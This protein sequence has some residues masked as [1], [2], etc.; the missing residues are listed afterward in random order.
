MGVGRFP[1]TAADPS[2]GINIISCSKVKLC[3]ELIYY[4]C[5]LL[6]VLLIAIIIINIITSCRIIIVLGISSFSNLRDRAADRSKNT[7]A[8]D[9][10]C[11][12]SV[13]M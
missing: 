9:L 2:L 5:Y 10:S 13:C 12:L 4:Y 11:I 3:T 1:R 7:T 6:I 8:K